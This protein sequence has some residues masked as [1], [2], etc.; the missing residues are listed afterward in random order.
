M[1]PNKPFLEPQIQALRAEEPSAD[2][3]A[4]AVRMMQ[5]ASPVRKS[6][7]RIWLRA[8][9]IAMP[10]AILGLAFLFKPQ[11]ASAAALVQIADA[12]RAR[13]TRHA[14]T[15]KPD[16]SGSFNLTYETWIENGKFLSA[17][18][19]GY[20]GLR[21]K[22]YD[23]H[24][25]FMVS[26]AGEGFI[27]DTE[28]SGM[29]IEDLGSYLAYPKA[30]ILDHRSGLR[31]GGQI[32]DRYSVAI[33]GTRFDLF[34]DPSTRLP[35][36]REV[37]DLQGRRL[38]ERNIYDY[39]TDIPD[40]RFLPPAGTLCDYP[41]L[42][43]ELAK[44][45]AQ[46]GQKQVVGGV[47]IS[48]KAVIVGRY[49][50]LALWTG[51]ARG[52]YLKEGSMWVEGLRHGGGAPPDPFRV[53]SLDQLTPSR[54]PVFANGQLI[55]G[56]ELGAGEP[57]TLHPPFKISVAVWAEDPSQPLISTDGRK[58]GNR[59]KTVGRA[60]FVVDDPLYAESPYRL[61]WKPSGE[62]QVAIATGG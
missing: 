59:S 1:H 6:R 50:V 55:L 38:I 31:E 33:S 40:A 8:A 22:G 51:G 35:L 44:R 9:A 7:T 62:D 17:M 28:P 42:R 45:L 37:L 49:S 58:L 11:T 13:T 2:A 23:G 43:V 10:A 24:R 30:L 12:M 48:L 29:P 15:F 4:R 54:S 60:T 61:L 14:M 57:I 21:L 56:D 26:S 47:A 16:G 25:M 52:N 27:D 20:G 36:R 53:P 5:I 19:D 18:P 39:P 46:P 3:V 32:V 41:A 34:V